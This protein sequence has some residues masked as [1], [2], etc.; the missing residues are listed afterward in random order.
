V[1]AIV[2]FKPAGVERPETFDVR[3]VRRRHAGD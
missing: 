2:A 1:T 3:F